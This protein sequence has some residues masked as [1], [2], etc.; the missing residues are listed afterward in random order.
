MYLPV[1][2][3]MAGFRQWLRKPVILLET[4]TLAFRG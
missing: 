3:S 1:I 2:A 4:Q